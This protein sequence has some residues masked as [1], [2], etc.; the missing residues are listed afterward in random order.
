MDGLIENGV[1]LLNPV[2]PSDHNDLRLFKQR[3]GDKITFLGGISTTVA[4]MNKKEIESHIA[5]VME[6]GCKG[7]RFMPRTKS[8]IPAMGPDKAHFFIDTLAHYRERYGC[9][10]MKHSY[11]KTRTGEN[12]N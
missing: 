9:I 2:G 7:N 11:R 8:G 12:E 10:G 1:D 6:I 3:W 5:Q 4:Q